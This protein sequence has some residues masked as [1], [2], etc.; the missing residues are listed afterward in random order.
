MILAV[1]RASYLK[2]STLLP[3]ALGWRKK[4]KNW[5][6]GKRWVLIRNGGLD[7][8][9]W[10]VLVA[11]VPAAD[12]P[13]IQ[14]SMDYTQPAQSHYDLAKELAPLREKGVLILGSGNMVHNL[15]RVVL[16]GGGCE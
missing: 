12:I 8:G 15:R 11:D 5:F 13:V 9:C 3:A 10:S 16:G 2:H 6:M 7:H 14:L 4:P 1:S